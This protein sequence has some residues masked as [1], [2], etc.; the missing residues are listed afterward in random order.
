MKTFPVISASFATIVLAC[1]SPFLLLGFL[2]WS[3]LEW[4]ARFDLMFVTL[5]LIPL[6]VFGWRYAKQEK[7]VSGIVHLILMAGVAGLCLIWGLLAFGS[8]SGPGNPVGPEV[9]LTGLGAIII[10]IIATV[11]AMGVVRNYVQKIRN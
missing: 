4:K 2:N 1:V 6:T 10:G 5:Y 8:K 3:H 7:R 11:C 9:Q